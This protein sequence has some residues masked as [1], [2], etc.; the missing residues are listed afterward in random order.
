MRSHDSKVS[1]YL[2]SATVKLHQA[3]TV[4]RTDFLSIV[5]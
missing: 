4:M 3:E 5:N 1:S 2:G